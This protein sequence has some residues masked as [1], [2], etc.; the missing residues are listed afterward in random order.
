[1]NYAIMLTA[2]NVG[3][4]H[5]RVSD[6]NA[7]GLPPRIPKRINPVSSPASTNH[8]MCVM[9]TA[10]LGEAVFLAGAY[11]SVRLAAIAGVV[12]VVGDAGYCIQRNR[13]ERT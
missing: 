9:L 11:Y 8:A 4:Q 7:R 12:I 13:K 6:S 5:V 10:L 1:M 2:E 3:S